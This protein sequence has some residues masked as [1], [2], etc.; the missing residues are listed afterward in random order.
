MCD[1]FSVCP[2]LVVWLYHCTYTQL[3]YTLSCTHTTVTPTHTPTHTHTHTH[4]HTE[5]VTQFEELGSND[6][7]ST[8][9]TAVSISSIIQQSVH[10]LIVQASVEVI[11]TSLR[12]LIDNQERMFEQI[13]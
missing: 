13:K 12:Q 11:T 10:P 2:N 8:S 7:D 6:L 9:S 5:L 3:S 4:T 1:G